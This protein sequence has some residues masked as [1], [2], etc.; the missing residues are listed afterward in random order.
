MRLRDRAIDAFEALAGHYIDEGADEKAVR[1][2]NRLLALDPL[3]EGVHRTLM[4]LYVKRRQP[5]SALRQ[6]RACR[7]I[8]ERELGVPPE[9][10]THRLYREIL[11]SRGREEP[12][13]QAAA[14]REPTSI[15]SL[16]SSPSPIADSEGLDPASA[17]AAPAATPTRELRQATVMFADLSRFTQLSEELDLEELDELLQVYLATVDGI[18]EEHGGTI[19]K[20][21]GDGVM[22]VFDVPTARS[23]D[24]ERAVRAALAIHGAMPGISR[25]VGR[26]LR[27]HIGI[28][29]GQVLVAGTAP[30]GTVT[31]GCVNIASRLSDVAQPDETLIGSA[32][33]RAL[34]G[35]IDA[36]EARD[37]DLKDVGHT[38][39]PWRV[40]WFRSSGAFEQ[41]PFVGRRTELIQIDGVIGSCRD[42]GRGMTIYVRGE[43][44]IGK[45]RLIER[46]M[47]VAAREGFSCHRGL[48]LDFGTRQG[49][50][51]VR[52]VVRGVLQIDGKAPEATASAANRAIE[53]GLVDAEQR[54]SLNDLLS[55]P[56]PPELETIYGAMEQATRIQQVR[57]TVATLIARASKKTPILAVIEDIHWADPVIL[58]FLAGL[59][60]AVGDCPA[61][62]VMSARTESDPLD[63]AW[64]NSTEGGPFMTIDLAPLRNVEAAELARA[65]GTE[66]EDVATACI[67]RSGGNPLFLEQLLRS[68]EEVG[69]DAV[70]GTVRS[71]VRRE[72]M[73]SS[74]STNAQCKPRR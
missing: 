53:D 66:D 13:Q 2:A 37:A 18:I 49:D 48:V 17:T 34:A 64:R 12:S 27:T 73:G 42:T 54:A 15:D 6:Y 5:N 19:D 52:A 44:G 57:E 38:T 31:G 68:A 35:R 56:Q 21:L 36:E 58:E 3:Q 30:R 4:R 65:M 23:N 29:S 24:A 43:A 59:T 51:P 63:R 67:D 40:K 32:L 45:T 28:S 16:A 33:R 25:R 22:A 26:D 70:P 1:T 46:F 69:Q 8:L 74:Q 61:I 10:E 39:R 50:D 41:M 11:E 72:S 47:T 71:L 9:P 62:L 60:A 55:L 14:K 7:E 20:H